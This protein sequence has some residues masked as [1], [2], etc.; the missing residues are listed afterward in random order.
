MRRGAPYRESG[1]CEPGRRTWPGTEAEAVRPYI[2]ENLAAERASCTGTRPR[3][4]GPGRRAVPT[5]TVP[6]VIKLTASR[7][8]SRVRGPAPG[9]F[10]WRAL[11]RAAHGIRNF[12]HEQVYLWER[13]YLASRALVPEDGPLTWIPTLDGYALAGC[14]LPAPGDAA[15]RDRRT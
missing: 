10:L 5:T 3:R 14:H 11:R 15:S 7:H 6:G 4:G 12:H 8:E 2:L 9:A 1:C 13:F